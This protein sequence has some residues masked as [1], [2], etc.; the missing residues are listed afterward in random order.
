ME[1]ERLGAVILSEAKNPCSSRPRCGMTIGVRHRRQTGR[2]LG[3]PGKANSPIAPPMNAP[4]VAEPTHAREPVQPLVDSQIDSAIDVYASEA[5]AAPASAPRTIP[6]LSRCILSSTARSACAT[7]DSPTRTE[8]RS[9]VHTRPC[10]VEE[11][12]AVTRT[13]QRSDA[14]RRSTDGSAA[15]ESAFCAPTG[16]AN[17]SRQSTSA[18]RANR[19]LVILQHNTV[20]PSLPPRFVPT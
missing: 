1:G 3:A 5:I 15:V 16:A 18:G 11:S 10:I 9:T 12:S 6:R 13:C 19:D 20:R 14:A 17:A 8:S 4:T 2:Q 7:R